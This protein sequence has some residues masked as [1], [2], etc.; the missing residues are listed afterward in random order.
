MYITAPKEI[1]A[2]LT[3]TVACF[4]P[5]RAKDLSASLYVVQVLLYF[6][7]VCNL[8]GF[9]YEG[10]NAICEAVL[11]GG[12]VLSPFT[13]EDVFSRFALLCLSAYCLFTFM[14]M[15][16]HIKPVVSVNCTPPI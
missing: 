2:I 9:V 11:G 6:L 10:Y 14:S 3:E 15:F 1:H 5:G 4:L 16:I 12:S 8:V 13:A 7:S